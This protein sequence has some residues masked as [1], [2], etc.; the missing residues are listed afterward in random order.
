MKVVVDPFAH[1]DVL[2]SGVQTQLAADDPSFF[3]VVEASVGYTYDPI[4]EYISNRIKYDGLEDVN[5]RPLDNIDGYEAYRDDLM[6]AKNA[7]HMADLKRAIDENLARRDI[8]AK[9]TFGQHFFAGLADPVNLVALPFGGPTV[10]MAR[11]FLRTGGSVAGLTA[12]QEAG[13]ATFDPVGTK[14]EVA[15][16]VGSAFVIGGLLGS[17]ISIPASRR[18]AAFEATEK[19]LG[20]H[21]AVLRAQP[22]VNKNLPAPTTE[23]PLSQV[24]NYELDAVT[25]T[26]PRVIQQLQ[27]SADE[28]ARLVDERRAEFDRAVTPDDM[29]KTKAALD[30]AEESA[31]NIQSELNARKNEYDMFKREADLRKADQAA[32]DA[33]DDPYGL[34]KNLWTDSVFYKFVT[35]PM[36]RVLQDTKITDNAKKII[37]GIA[38]DSGILLNMHRG[39]LRLGPSVYQKAAMRDGE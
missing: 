32:I 2:Y 39:G 17:A 12:L 25:G 28:A 20:E 6:D 29:A 10:G 35:T 38:G 21:A 30:E 3:D 19:S 1:N 13:R 8:L 27:E 9:A 37:L 7:E 15:I 18:A 5:Y 14:T 34:P 4:I 31:S 11:S 23:R 22:D 26:A 36:K 33:M 16:N 24:E